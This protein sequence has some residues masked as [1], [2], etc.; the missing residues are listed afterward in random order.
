MLEKKEEGF[1]FFSSTNAQVDILISNSTFQ[2]NRA[3]TYGGGIQCFGYISHLL[4]QQSHFIENTA[5]ASGGGVSIE[6]SENSEN[7][8]GVAFK[9]VTLVH[10]KAHKSWWWA[11]L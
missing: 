10:N 6:S 2:E 4:V 8:A 1:T 3:N 5:T 7:I 9:N 11:V